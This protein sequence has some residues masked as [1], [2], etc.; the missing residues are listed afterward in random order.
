MAA[1]LDSRTV[2][3]TDRG[4]SERGFDAGKQVFGRKRHVLVSTLGPLL[5]IV[6]A[7]L[8]FARRFWNDL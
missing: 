1:I 5:L 2:K 4:G 6:S 3:T 8:V 7:A